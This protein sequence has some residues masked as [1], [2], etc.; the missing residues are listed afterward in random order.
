VQKEK[1]TFGQRMAEKMAKIIGSWPFI[2]CQT[3]FLIS[4]V[5]CNTLISTKTIPH[6]DG[7]PFIL[8]N[9]FLSLQ[10]GFTGPLIM[11]ASNRQEQIDRQRA[12]QTLHITEAILTILELHHENIKWKD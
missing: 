10:A 11:I 2:I 3:F 6:W 8:M 5:I 12:E 4:W 9:L 7:Y 1:L